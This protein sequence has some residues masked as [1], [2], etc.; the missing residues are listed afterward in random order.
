M[1][2]SFIPLL[3]L[4]VPLA[5][6]AVFVFVGGL[7]GVFATLALV[8][9]TAVIGTALL[10]WQGFGIMARISAE[11]KAGRVPGRDLAHGAMI[12]VA[13]VLL[14][15][16][17]FVTDS[18][19]FLLFVPAIRDMAWRLIRSRITVVAAG[20]AGGSF[21]SGFP[22][23]PDGGPRPTDGSPVV[24]LDS[25]DYRR[26]PDSPWSG[27]NGRLSDGQHRRRDSEDGL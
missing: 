10:R 8:L 1:R 16:P 2:F 9:V 18:L 6:I 26:D 20:A 11:T 7:I 22:P 12:L 19:G 27:G 5:E 3:L 13:G 14:L 25:E 17:G 4:A 24:D 21:A 23:R 15:T